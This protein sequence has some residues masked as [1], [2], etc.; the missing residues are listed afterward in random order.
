MR[1]VW[2]IL[3][4]AVIVTASYCILSPGGL[5]ALHNVQASDEGEGCNTSTTC[6]RVN[7]SNA[8]YCPEATIGGK[9]CTGCFVPNGSTGC[10]TCSGGA[11][12]LD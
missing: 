10:G 8:C 1:R 6:A 5:Y 12:E 7:G 11:N 2:W 4:I 3:R 9:G